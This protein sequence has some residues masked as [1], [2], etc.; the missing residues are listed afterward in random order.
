MYSAAGVTCLWYHS[1]TTELYC[2]CIVPHRTA[3]YRTPYRRLFLD[4]L[5][6]LDHLE[7]LRRFFFQGA[8]DWAD[9]LA[10]RL[11]AH[12]DTLAPLAGHQAEA[13]LADAARVGEGASWC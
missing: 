2:N 7:A 13:L 3:P 5:K 9:A 1:C 8:G 12:A 11:G 4:E 6:V 10:Q